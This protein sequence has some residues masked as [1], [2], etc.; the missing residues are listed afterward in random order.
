[1][2]ITTWSIYCVLLT[3]NL[4][5]KLRHYLITK[6]VFLVFRKKLPKM[7]KTEQE[8]LTAGSVW[9]DRELYSGKPNWSRLLNLSPCKLSQREQEYLDGPVQQLCDR[10]DDWRIT[11]KD[12]DLPKEIWDFIK[13]SGMFGMIIPTSYGGLG[14]SA[15]AHSQVVMKITSRSIAAAVTV[16]VPNSL[17]PAK[18]I[19]RYGTKEQKKH[20]LKRLA[21]GEEIPCFALTGP[22]AGSD[23]NAMPDRGVVTYGNHNGRKVLGICINCEKRYIT[24]APL[25][26]SLD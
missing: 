26:H 13:Q 10:L 19:H 11:H 25:Q 9:W 14:F 16:M 7:S 6:P 23:A 17:G 20:Y 8:A 24:L 5:P 22:Q 3:F 18:L 21:S 15:Y 1:M 4:K 12:Q 2:A